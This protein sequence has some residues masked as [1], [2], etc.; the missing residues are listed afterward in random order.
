MICILE[1]VIDD[2]R[3]NKEVLNTIIKSILNK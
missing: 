1:N 2:L 3:N